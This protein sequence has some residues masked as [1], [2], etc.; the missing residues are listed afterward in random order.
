VKV[1]AG[2]TVSDWDIKMRVHLVT[3]GYRFRDIHNRCHGGWDVAAM[4]TGENDRM[5][6]MSRGEHDGENAGRVDHK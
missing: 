4:G 6:A 5:R 1:P 2:F 3:S